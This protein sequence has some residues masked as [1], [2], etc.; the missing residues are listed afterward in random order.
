[1][2]PTLP[3]APEALCHFETDL[4]GER[5]AVGQTHVLAWPGLVA[6]ATAASTGIDQLLS[7]LVAGALARRPPKAPFLIFWSALAGAIHLTVTGPGGRQQGTWL[8]D[9]PGHRGAGRGAVPR[10]ATPWAVWDGH[11][12]VRAHV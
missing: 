11:R 7:G 8:L 12:L 6:A 4:F 10:H 1:M 2:Y 3:F 5:R 9:A